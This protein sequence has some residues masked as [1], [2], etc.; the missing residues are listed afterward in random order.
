MSL[1]EDCDYIVG[2]AIIAV[3]PDAAVY[4]ALQGKTFP[5]GRVMLVAVGK[6]AWSMANAAKQA[7]GARIDSGFVITKYGHSM[8]P[9]EGITIFEAGHPVP[10]SASF[11]ATEAVLE[12][13]AALSPG[14][15]VLL[16]ISGGGS[17]LFESPLIKPEQSSRITEHLL[18]CG[19]GIVEM[20]TI[21]K[22]FSK[23]KGGRFA[24]HCEPASVFSIVLSDIIGD[25][26]DMIASGPAYPDSSTVEDA[27]RI[28][29]KYR[30]PLTDEMRQLLELETPKQLSNATAVVTGS[31]RELCLAA[32]NAA[33]EL[34]YQPTIL[35]DSLDCVAR[36][37]GAFL[38][39]IARFRQGTEHSL[40]L[41][42]GGET[43]VHLTGKGLGGRNQE[44]ALAAAPGI[45]GLA[46]TAVFSLG[47]DGTDGPTDAA[48]GYVDGGTLAA[49]SAKGISVFETLR[50]N[51]AY[52]ALESCDGLIKTG[53]TGTNVN[54][55]TVL[56]IRREGDA[57]ER[58]P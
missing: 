32:A 21:R 51:D 15:T 13:T 12:A 26:L 6:A 31:V 5:G 24:R 28:A 56:L 2:K 54:D 58:K 53:P 27:T 35:T 45:A 9:L 1:R 41:I 17:A 48:G 38:S 23:V 50:A 39:A 8:G 10:D 44:L 49:L 3:Q 29:D 37:A 11:A 42:A 40:A 46:G 34:G 14:D 20:N 22:R 4:R 30:L 7:M 25:P 19:A 57:A 47:S 55:V 43:V 36:E 52:H 18:A 33:R 16:L